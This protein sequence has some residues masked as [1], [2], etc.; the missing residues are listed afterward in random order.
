MATTRTAGNDR[1][2]PQCEVISEVAHLDVLDGEKRL[3]YFHQKFSRE[4]S[5]PSKAV[6]RKEGSGK[7]AETGLEA[8]LASQEEGRCWNCQGDLSEE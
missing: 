6:S 4:S 1:T 5:L 2:L 3:H 8:T 7:I